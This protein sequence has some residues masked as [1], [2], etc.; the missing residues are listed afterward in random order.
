LAHFEET[1]VLPPGSSKTFVLRQ[2]G[3]AAAR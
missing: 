2:R 1:V 3:A